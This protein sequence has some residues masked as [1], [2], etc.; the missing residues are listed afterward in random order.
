MTTKIQRLRQ[1]YGLRQQDFANK[2]RIGQSAIQSVERGNRTRVSTARLIAE[3]LGMGIS[4]LFIAG[5][6]PRYMHP[7]HTFEIGE[8]V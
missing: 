1:Y 7:I 5:T 6:D 8:E 3:A 2:C 4:E